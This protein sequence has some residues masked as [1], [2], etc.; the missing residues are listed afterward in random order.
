MTQP[1]VQ[2]ISPRK[3]ALRPWVRRHR[4]ILA[5]LLFAAVVLFTRSWEG[6]L[7][8][9]AVHYAAVAKNIL[10][11]GDWITL[12]DNADLVYA[13]K[14]PLMFWLV[15]ANFRL[16]GVSTYAAR[17]WS[18]AFA[19]GACLLAY[20]VGRRLF[21][22]VAGMLAGCMT[23]TFS[24]VLINAVE[25]RLDSA[26]AFSAALAAYGALRAADENRPRWLLL[27]GF[28]GGLGMM[29]K[30]SAGVHVAAVTML[31]LALRRPR[32]LVHPALLS[33]LGVAA[34][35]AA[36]WH[37]AMIARHGEAFTGRYFGEQIGSRLTLGGHFFRNLGENVEALLVRGLPWWPLGLYALA[38]WR[39]LEP[40]RRRGALLALLWIAAVA[41]LMAV[42]PKRY[43]RYLLPAY[44][45]LGLL[46]GLGASCLLPERVRPAVPKGVACYALVLVTVLAT[47]PVPLHK[48]RC[49]GF[50]EASSLLDRAAPGRT[51][52]SYNPG[53]PSGPSRHVAQWSLRSKVIYYLNRSLVN[54]GS[55]EELAAGR[56]EFVVAGWEHVGDLT[57][58]GYRVLLELDDHYRL[59][60]RCRGGIATAHGGSALPAGQGGAR[61][62]MAD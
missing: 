6:D 40:A 25:L 30:P 28:A 37:L 33:A 57:G 14:P 15:A 31:V 48:Y 58:S 13:N 54:R 56:D 53:V 55:V 46:A 21:G 60:H 22:P 62:R 23:A 17:F 12:H 9:D 36:P 47:V 10:A 26:V 1:H 16:F 27:A 43:D 61:G 4:E 41:V 20:A 45:A 42:A 19:L 8:G 39:R 2:A 29:I 11:T 51:I 52:A 44:P 32:L 18:C 35:I 34:V 59:L 7:H 38:R 50:A 49:R 5:V 24:G 3:Q